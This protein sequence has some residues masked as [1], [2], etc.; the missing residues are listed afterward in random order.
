MNCF[1]RYLWRVTGST[2]SNVWVVCLPVH[3]VTMNGYSNNLRSAKH[4]CP[5]CAYLSMLATQA[6]QFG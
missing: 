6:E 1:L 5:D 4:F 2:G 3:G